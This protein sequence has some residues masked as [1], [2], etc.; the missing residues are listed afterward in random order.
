M[1]PGLIGRHRISMSAEPLESTIMVLLLVFPAITPTAVDGVDIAAW[2]LVATALIG[3]PLLGWVL[4]A[5][6]VRRFVCALRA[7]ALVLVGYIAPN[8]TPYWVLHDRPY[9]LRALGVS[10]PC[11]ESDVLTAYR[12]KVKHLHPDRGGQMDRFLELQRHFEQAMHLVRQD[13]A[14]SDSK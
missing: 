9:C 7:R 13:A 10:L 6:D 5:L 1:A 14:R 2:S 8:Q 12:S 11:T 3:L 4:L